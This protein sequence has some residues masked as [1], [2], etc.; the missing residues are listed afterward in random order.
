MSVEAGLCKTIIQEDFGN[1]TAAVA[2]ILILKGRLTAS[3]IT[4]FSQYTSTRV[5]EILVVLI[6]HGIVYFSEPKEPT[7]DKK[8]ST[9]YEIDVNKILMRLR[10]GRLM[11]VTEEHYGKAVSLL[12]YY[13]CTIISL[14]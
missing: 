11:R 7:D 1:Y 3:D 12:S 13:A 14:L 2:N 4:R 6:E 5:R 8:E 9:Y 10:M